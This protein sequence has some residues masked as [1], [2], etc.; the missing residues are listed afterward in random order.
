M[1]HGNSLVAEDHLLLPLHGGDPYGKLSRREEVA[2]G[3][4]TVGKPFLLHRRYRLFQFG[5]R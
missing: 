2:A 5:E 3:N 1:L 4:K